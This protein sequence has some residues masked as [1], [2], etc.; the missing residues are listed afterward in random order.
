MVLARPQGRTNSSSNND[1]YTRIQVGFRIEFQVYT[2]PL[3]YGTLWG[4]V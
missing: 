4:V 3:F 1:G 2:L